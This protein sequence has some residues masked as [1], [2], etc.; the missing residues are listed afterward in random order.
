LQGCF[1]Q[2]LCPFSLGLVLVC[3]YIAGPREQLWLWSDVTAT[4]DQ[5]NHCGVCRDLNLHSWE[6]HK[7]KFNSKTIGSNMGTGETK[8]QICTL[9][10]LILNSSL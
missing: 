4:G 7:I 2:I 10:K 6:A 8:I 1:S 5:C 9:E 3:G